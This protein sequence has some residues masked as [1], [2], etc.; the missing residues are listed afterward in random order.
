M[1]SLSTFQKHRE[2]VQYAPT[3]PSD[4]SWCAK[5]H[6][7]P[8]TRTADTAH[9]IIRKV[10]SCQAQELDKRRDIAYLVVIEYEDS[11]AGEIYRRRYLAYLIICKVKPAQVVH[12]GKR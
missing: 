9:L 7:Y 12:R 10:E 6:E 1:Y 5:H 4:Q 2:I 11:Q 8:H 3:T